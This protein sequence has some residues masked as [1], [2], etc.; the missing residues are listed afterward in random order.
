MLSEVVFP[1]SCDK[2]QDDVQITLRCPVPRAMSRAEQS[3]GAS[4]AL[5]PPARLPARRFK[6]GS[7]STC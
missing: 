1:L 6:P 4:A 5:R 2:T 3:R 7:G